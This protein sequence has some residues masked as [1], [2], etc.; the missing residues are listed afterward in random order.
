MDG[1]EKVG[2]NA[3]LIPGVKITR[4]SQKAIES[5]ESFKLLRTSFR[6]AQ[7]L[8]SSQGAACKQNYPP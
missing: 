3:S 7:E 8:P 4:T 2:P 5:Y 1:W 6:T